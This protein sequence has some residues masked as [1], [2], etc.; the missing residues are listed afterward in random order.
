MTAL[1]LGDGLR[2]IYDVGPGDHIGHEAHLLFAWRLLDEA[3][4][5]DEAG[6]IACLTIRHLAELGGNPDR[7]HCTVTLFWTRM[8]DT[9]RRTEPAAATLEAALQAHPELRDA[10]LPERYWSDLDAE[11]ARERW[12][13]P[14]LASMP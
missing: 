11:E 12:V 10:R 7:Y 13:E 3:D 8:L 9:I 4:D 1:D 14:D 6:R 5:A 2:L